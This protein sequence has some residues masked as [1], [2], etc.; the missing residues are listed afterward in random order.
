MSRQ[1]QKKRFRLGEI[2]A[3][4]LTPSLRRRGFAHGDIV[5]AW[6]AI[7]GERLSRATLP[8]RLVWPRRTTEPGAET[9]PATLVL[10]VDGPAAIEI[11]HQSTELLERINVYF[12]YR[13]VG[14]V[15]IVQAP[16]PGRRTAPAR[17]ECPAESA[18]RVDGLVAPVADD[19]L[20]AAL[21]RLGRNVAA[22]RRFNKT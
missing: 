20:K 5:A 12:G 13:A 18:A 9:E 11:Q 19:G 15:K 22:D 3:D 4:V 16:L 14:K 2:T 8:E 7:V 10:R 6:Q 17:P 21:A 1:W